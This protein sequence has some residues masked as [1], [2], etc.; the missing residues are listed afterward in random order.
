MTETVPAL[1]LIA[2]AFESQSALMA[3]LNAEPQLMNERTGLGETP[4]HYLAVENQLDAVR[5]LIARGAAVSTL[6]ECRTTPLSDAASLGYE[7]MVG[8]LLEHGAMLH[9]PGQEEP[10]LH[11]AVR[12]GTVQVVQ[13][14]LIAGASPNEVDDMMQ[15]PLHVAAESDDCVPVLQLLLGAGAQ[16]SL[17]CS[18]GDTPL[19]L[20]LRRGSSRCAEILAK[21][22]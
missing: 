3:L 17:R 20:A 9:V 10:V 6:N 19:D 14:L 7:E 18:F 12:H 8:L 16:T 21:F 11:G 5:L 15:T 1:R 22:N 2:A 4:L 13:R